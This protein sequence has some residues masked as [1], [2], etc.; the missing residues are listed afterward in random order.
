M[1][2]GYSTGMSCWY[3]VIAAQKEVMD[4]Y[5]A[6]GYIVDKATADVVEINTKDQVF[7]TML[8]TQQI[9]HWYQLFVAW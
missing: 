4:R 9:Q 8:S 3:F 1:M 2:E 6:N 5:T 7:L